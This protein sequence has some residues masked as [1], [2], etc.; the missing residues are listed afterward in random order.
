MTAMFVSKT[1]MET[2]RLVVSVGEA[3]AAAGRVLAGQE[4]GADGSTE[5]LHVFLCFF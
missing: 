4:A 2:R 3:D 5:L 1:V